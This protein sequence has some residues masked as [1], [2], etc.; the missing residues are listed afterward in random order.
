MITGVRETW[1]GQT[2]SD[3]YDG[4]REY[5][6]VFLVL[7]DDPGESPQA[8]RG[9]AGI[10]LPGV[11]IYPDDAAAVCKS[12]SCRR[13]D[14]SRQL[15]EVTCSFEWA[16]GDKDE[17]EDQNPL[18][19]PPKIRWTST[20]ITKPVVKDRNGKAC[21][22]SAGDYFDPPLEAEFVRWTAN[23]QFNAASVPVGIKSYAGAINSSSITIDGDAVAAER[24][25][26]VGLDIGEED[27]ENDVTFR[28]VTLA[29][30]CRDEDDDPFDVEALDQ[31]FRV[32]DG[33]Q[34]L[35]ILI[36]D[37]EGN[38]NRPS[39]P[40]L[41]NGFGGKLSNPSP[42][43]AVFLTFEIPRRKDFTIFPGIS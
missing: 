7:S 20:L 18:N 43:N 15:W 32:K 39:S 33:T 16:P 29:V 17:P 11:T 38:K 41:L 35:D 4:S 21:V 9:H 37:E 25:R 5:E 31:G 40:V 27:S 10:P 24:A 42:D 28:S 34:L 14:E 3:Q 8:V 30:E 22:N 23:I 6:M 36:E 13:S 26:I 12:R 19:R 1:R 2:W